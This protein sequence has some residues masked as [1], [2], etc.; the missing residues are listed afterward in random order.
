MFLRSFRTGYRVQT[1]KLTIPWETGL[2]TCV[3]DYGPYSL[4]LLALSADVKTNRPEEIGEKE[5]REALEHEEIL[6]K[7]VEGPE[8]G[9]A[10]QKDNIL[11]LEF[12]NKSVVNSLNVS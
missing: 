6:P 8:V 10:H 1:V 4:D 9:D 2:L 3:P 11:M 5:E 7:V 12:V